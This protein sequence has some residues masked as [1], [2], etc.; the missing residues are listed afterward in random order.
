M[1]HTMQTSVSKR[2]SC[3]TQDGDLRRQKGGRNKSMKKSRW[4]EKGDIFL[5]SSFFLKL[6]IH[7]FFSISC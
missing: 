2:C 1:K 6:S 4:E 5:L 7:N 3:K